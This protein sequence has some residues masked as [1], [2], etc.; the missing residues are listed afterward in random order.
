MKKSLQSRVHWPQIAALGFM[1]SVLT[2]GVN[3]QQACTY[4]PNPNFNAQLPE[5]PVTNPATLI[6]P[7]NGIWTPP[8][9]AAGYNPA[10]NYCIPNFSVSPPLRKFKD[11]LPGLN[12]ANKNGN[13]QYIPVAVPDK[14]TFPGTDYYEIGLKQYNEQ[15]HSDLPSTGSKLRGYYQ[16]NGPDKTNHYLG[17]MIIAD[18]GTAVRFKYFNE[19]AKTGDLDY[20]L[21]LP[22]DRLLMGAG[23][24]RLATDGVTACD[25]MVTDTC[26]PYADNRAVIHLHGGLTPWISDGTPHQW[27]TPAGDSTFYK[28][29]DSFQNVPDMIG[30]GPN[31]FTP[32]P[33]DG[34][35]TNYYTN[36]QSGRLL[37]YHDHTLGL[38]RLNIYAGM[39]AP[40]LIVDPTEKDLINRGVLPDQQNIVGSGLSTA[41]VSQYKYGIPLLI[42]DKSFVNGDF[43]GKDNNGKDVNVSANLPGGA[44]RAM[45]STKEADP[46]WF[47]HVNNSAHGDLW[48]PHEYIPNE[49]P[50]NTWFDPG[51]NTY[52]ANPMGRWDY[53][54]WM[55]P[56][57]IPMV[58]TLPSPTAIPETYGD[59]MIVNGTVFPYLQLPPTA[60]RFRIL[61]GSND[62]FLNLQL[63]YASTKDGVL[64]KNNAVP[65][66]SLCTEVSMVPAM[67]YKAFNNLQVSVGNITIDTGSMPASW[68]T[69]GRAG[70]VPYW[71]HAGPDILQIGNEAGMLARVAQ[72]PSQPVDFDHN[73]RSVT[74]NGITSRSLMMPSAVRSDVVVDF[75]GVPAGSALI[76]YN[77]APAP[78]PLWDNRN[79]YYTNDEDQSMGGGAPSTEPGYG[80][81]TRTVMQ[82]RI[83]GAPTVPSSFNVDTLK[84][85]LPK[86]YFVAQ[87]PP[88]VPQ[89]YY[90][91]DANGTPMNVNNVY[92]NVADESLNITGQPQAI[93]RVV[94]TAPGQS[95]SVAPTVKFSG[96][97]CKDNN[98][99]GQLAFPAATASLNGVTGLNL[100]TG[101]TGYNTVPTVRITPAAGGGGA[102]AVAQAVITGGVVTGVYITNPGSGYLQAPTVTITGGGGTGAT[103]TANVTLGSVGDITLSPSNI[104]CLTAPLVTLVP[105]KG[106]PGTGATASTTLF[107]SLVLDGK[108]LI[109]GFDREFGRMNAMLG[110]TPNPLTPAVGA[111]PVVGVAY[112]VDPPTEY[113]TGTTTYLWRIM[114]IGVDSHAVHL[115]LFDSQLVNRVDWTGVIKPPYGDELG[116][117]DTIQT[118]PFE[119]IIIAL[120]PAAT[121]M[122][123]PFTIPNSMRLLDPTVPLGSTGIFSPVAPP[124]G[125]AAVA[126][127]TNVV[128]SYGWEYVWHCHL[129]GHEENDMMRPIVFSPEMPTGG[130][131]PQSLT[132]AGT[133]VNAT[134]AYQTVTLTNSGVNTLTI[135]NIAFSPADFLRN[136]GAVGAAQGAA[137][138]G[139]TCPASTGSLLPGASCTINVVFKPT[140]NGTING[141]LTV[142]DDSMGRLGTQQAVLLTGTGTAPVAT[143]ST[144]TLDF[145]TV[146]VGSTSPALTVILSNTG[147]A[148]LQNISATVPGSLFTVSTAGANGCKTTLAAGQSCNVYVSFSPT[149][150]GVQ[151]ATLS[152][153]S[154]SPGAPNTVSLSGNGAVVPM[155][156]ITPATLDFGTNKL[157]QNP[158][159]QTV[160]VTNTGGAG[161]TLVVA[162]PTT[163]APFAVTGSACSLAKNATCTFTVSY[164]ATTVGTSPVNLNFQ[165]NSNRQD[166]TTSTAQ[167]YA[168]T[169]TTAVSQAGLTPSATVFGPVPA[170]STTNATVTLT[171][172]GPVAMAVS[173]IALNTVSGTSNVFAQTNNCPATLAANGGSCTI[174]LAYQ[175]TVSSVTDVAELVVTDDSGVTLGSTV[176]QKLQFTGT[177]SAPMPVAG[178]TG[179][180]NFGQG[181]TSSGQTATLNATLTN[182]G[183]GTLNIASIATTTGAYS[184]SSTTCSTVNGLPAGNSCTITV[185]FKPTRTR[186]NYTGTLT[187]TDNSNN[188]ANSKQ[189]LAITGRSK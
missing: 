144:S 10:L 82:F 94:V 78:M 155:A 185:A 18:K 157:G 108:N 65:D 70:G 51:T 42:Q 33:G 36:N 22:V 160:T 46:F 171:N 110:S 49:D 38:T 55:N 58:D 163:S 47:K 30:T 107:G 98:G 11:A 81:N 156:S 102:G 184:V 14:S 52:G 44:T 128:N 25:P 124:P 12:S 32:T 120:R 69:D 147:S 115:H 162:V 53:A 122:Q 172:S 91:A 17:P 99:N 43:N 75:T 86:A 188:V 121:D 31:Q 28:K 158:G 127:T 143:L 97:T 39:V 3:A 125:V 27:I 40:Y 68:P 79:D 26:A 176:T 74:L 164:A 138:Q 93:D 90:P 45:P 111:G 63:Y 60:V 180:L 148:T 71:G 165:T 182:G 61:N 84:A 161:T 29:G 139:G 54:P 73:T 173:S 133:A 96:G 113:L 34:I 179:T 66:L 166:A 159:T 105:G 175:P 9:G 88:H 118:H 89:N 153:A 167:A 77:D 130:L 103:A 126:Q 56:P 50:F 92:A 131:N 101:G 132:F 134:S 21:P 85:E 189:T 140:T 119:D 187:V 142:T 146:N 20:G 80:P 178:L 23:P 136:A 13:G 145:G 168:L 62:R 87:K 112:F 24:G 76:M 186:T 183:S 5:D 16:K 37:F 135:S 4:P 6:T 72:W 116:W 141:T 152:I 106:N 2:F 104:K 150:A 41:D 95:Y 151:N 83:K 170:G 174:S 7:Y 59:S 1:L 19:L 149:A 123:L 117:R 15:M 154:N 57:A 48:L 35:G 169:G 64:C 177:T 114:H 67:D 129:L 100:L 137:T 109:E 181:V 8:A